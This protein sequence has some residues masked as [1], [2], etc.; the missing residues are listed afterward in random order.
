MY[1]VNGTKFE[2]FTKAI[3][4]AQPIRAEVIEVATGL[5]RWAPAA[6]KART[7]HVLVNDDGTKTE[8]GKVRR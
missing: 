7:R 1:D 8:F 2:S 3:A 4:F 5:R 6:I